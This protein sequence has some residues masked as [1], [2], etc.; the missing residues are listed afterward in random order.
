VQDVKENG[1]SDPNFEDALKRL[2]EI[3]ES[4]EEGEI[5]LDDL[6]RKY[7]EGNQLLKV[8]GKRLRDAELKIEMLKKSG[9]G[10]TLAPLDAETP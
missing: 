10:E 1:A 4:M 6:V 2:E 8:C 3:V 7:E 5:P 9:S